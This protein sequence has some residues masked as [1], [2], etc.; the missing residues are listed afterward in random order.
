MGQKFST[1]FNQAMP[2]ATTKYKSGHDTPH[3]KRGA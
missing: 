3:K 2:N 1:N